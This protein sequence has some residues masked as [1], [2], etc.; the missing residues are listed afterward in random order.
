[1]SFIHWQLLK[2]SYCAP[3]DMQN[4]GNT[5]ANTTKEILIDVALLCP[6][7]LQSNNLENW[8][9]ITCRLVRKYQDLQTHRFF[10][11]PLWSQH[12]TSLLHLIIFQ[13][14]SLAFSIRHIKLMAFPGFGFCSYL[15]EMCFLQTL[16]RLILPNTQVTLARLSLTHTAGTHPP[17]LASHSPSQY[18]VFLSQNTCYLRLPCFFI[19]CSS[20]CLPPYTGTSIWARLRLFCSPNIFG[21]YCT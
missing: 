12:I 21:S 11:L 8:W 14:P 1:M 17:C 19:C 18:L 15:P 2:S 13:P 3:G 7:L 9:L 6:W 16:T 5:A 20:A 10:F 4:V